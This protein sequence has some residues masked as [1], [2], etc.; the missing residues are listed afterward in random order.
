[1]ACGISFL[2]DNLVDSAVI[3]LTT[4]TANA[5][6]PLANMKIE[7]AAKKF[8]SLENDVV[9]RFDLQE[10]RTIDAIALHGDTNGTLGLTSA[11]VRTSLTTDFSSSTVTSVPLSAE[12]LMGYVYLESVDH[13]YVE[14]TL[15]GTGVFAEVSN[16]FIG[17]RIELLQQNLSIGSFEYGQIDQSKV[18][19]NDYGQKFIDKRNKIKTLG[20]NL[21]F[22]I[23]SEQ[24]ELDD[25]FIK[26]GK[27]QPLWMIVDKDGAGMIDG[28]YKLTIYGY[29]G[30]RPKWSAS[31]GQTYNCSVDIEQAG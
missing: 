15:S 26:H 7:A 31:G 5:Q 2:S 27:S 4:G 29:M 19:K 28:E 23:K 25:M 3:E 10:T 6:F 17:E 11:S 16:I 20:G 13:R 12:H 1:M 24:K 22:C 9:I 18:A 30:T 14:L 8:R 21:E